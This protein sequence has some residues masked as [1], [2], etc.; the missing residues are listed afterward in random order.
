MSGICQQAQIL[1]LE[2][3]N[4]FLWLKFSPSLILNPA[5]SGKHFETA[6]IDCH[7]HNLRSNTALTACSKL[8]RASRSGLGIGSGWPKFE[9]N[10]SIK[11]EK[12]SGSLRCPFVFCCFQVEQM[13]D[14]YN[15]SN[16][17]VSQKVHVI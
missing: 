15:Y 4:V 16:G 5:V 7:N 17:V 11:I 3:L 2:I 12:G 10:W 14:S 1:I 8:R 13:Q 9:T 6:S